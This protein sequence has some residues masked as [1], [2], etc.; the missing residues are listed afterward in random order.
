MDR[1]PASVSLHASSSK[2]H[3]KKG[4]VHI[5]MLDGPDI[6]ESKREDKSDGHGLD[7]KEK[8]S[9]KFDGNLWQQDWP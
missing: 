1:K 7:D 2:K 3:I 6:N 8:V 9:R 4:I 5:Q